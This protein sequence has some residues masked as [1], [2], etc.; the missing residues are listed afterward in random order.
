MRLLATLFLI[1]LLSACNNEAEND[2]IS[3]TFFPIK[4]NIEAELKK[5]DTIPIAILKYSSN[6]GLP[7]TSLFDKQ[8]FK[9]VAA[10]LYSPDISSKDLKKY[11]R[12]S[13]FMDNTINAIIMSYTTSEKEPVVRK[14]EVMIQPETERVRSIYVEKQE[15]QTLRKMIWTPGRNLQVITIVNEGPENIKTEKYTWE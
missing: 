9:K 5:L 4:G 10:E 1:S 12:E 13:V 3:K 2:D 15:G 11:Y 14:I 6:N 7:D 8:E